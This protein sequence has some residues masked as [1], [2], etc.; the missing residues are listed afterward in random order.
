MHFTF[1]FTASVGA[2]CQARGA[3]G[4]A[5]LQCSSTHGVAVAPKVKTSHGR[6]KKMP[7]RDRH[8]FCG[9]QYFVRVQRSAQLFDFPLKLGCSVSHRQQTKHS[10]TLGMAHG[11]ARDFQTYPTLVV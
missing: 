5:P 2:L 1:D 3:V 6:G 11:Y 10:H 4:A 9:C 7:L 8:A